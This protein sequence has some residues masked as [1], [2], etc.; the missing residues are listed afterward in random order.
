MKQ[1]GLFTL[2]LTLLFC[3]CNNNNEPDLE[4]ELPINS[5][6]IPNSIEINMNDIDDQQRGEIM[7]LVTNKHIVNNIAEVPSD[8]I[9]KNEAFYNVNYNEQTLLI[10]YLYK[11]WPFD[12]YS[13]RFYKNTKENIYNW[14]VKLGINPDYDED[15]EI[16]QLT[17]FAI[18]VRKLPAGAD[19]QTWYSV[20]QLGS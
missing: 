20:T 16:M 14:V 5:V 10:M 4:I 19:V 11:N 3:S 6:F 1:I 17:R 13:N 9:G 8:P 18:L 15:T 2:I 12:T 7:K